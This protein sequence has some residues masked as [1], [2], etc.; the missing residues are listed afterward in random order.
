[1]ERIKKTGAT[2]PILTDALC[3]VRRDRDT[4]PEEECEARSC[5]TTEATPKL[6][7]GKRNTTKK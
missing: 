5:A 3:G 1:L 4:R 2:R 6:V 7:S